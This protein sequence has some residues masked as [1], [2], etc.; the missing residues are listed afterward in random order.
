MQFARW[1]ASAVQLGTGQI[2]LIGGRDDNPDLTHYSAYAEVYTPGYGFHTLTGAYIDAFNASSAL[3]PRTWLTSS[4][5]VW[6]SD[7]ANI[8]SINPTGVGSVQ[9]IGQAPTQILWNIPAIMFAPDKVLLIGSDDSAWIMDMSGPTPVFQRTD[10]VTGGRIWSN[11]V[12]LPDGRVMISGGSAVDNQ[13]TGVDNTAAIWDPATGHWTIEANAAIPRLYHSDTILLADGSV[14]SLG[15][16][17]PGPLTNLNGEEY[18]PGYLFDVTGAPAVRPVIEDAPAQVQP[19]TEFTMHVDNPASIT[20]LALMPFGAVTHSFDMSARRLE[21]PFTVQADGSLK[22]DLPANSNLLT[23]GYWMLFAI[24]NND[25]PSIA[26]TVQVKTDPM[27]YDLPAQRPL[28]LLDSNMALQ[29][30]GDAAYDA[31]NDRYVLTPDA[32]TKHGSFIS[33]KR[34]D[35]STA[36]DISFQINLGGK[37]AGGDGVGFVLENDPAGIN[38]IGAAGGGQGL[39]GIQY[40]LGITFATNAATDQ[41]GFVKTADGSAQSVAVGLGNIEDGRWHQVYVVSNGQTISYTFDG[42]QMGAISLAAANALLNGSNLAYFGFTGDTS[43]ATEQ[44]QIQLLKLDATAEGGQQIHLDRANLPPGPLGPNKDPIAVN[45]AYTINKN[46]VLTV[47]AAAGVLANDYDPDGDP[48]RICPESRIVG[49]ALLL[50]PTNGAVTMNADGSFTYTPNT[51]FAG[52]DS[53]Y[54]CAEDG[55]ACAQGRV[56]ITV[57]G[58]GTPIN[59]ILGTPGNDVLVGTAGN[60][61]MSGGAGNDI[62]TGGRGNDTFVFGPG[63]GNDT[64]TDWSRARGNRDIIDL[65][66]FNFASFTDV[67]NRLVVNGADT[68]FNFGNGDTLTLQNTAAG[69]VTNLLVDDFKLSSASPV[70]TSPSTWTANQPV[71]IFNDASGNFTITDNVE[72]EVVGASTVNVSFASG[73]T[74]EL[75]LDASSQF[76]GQVTGFTDK[77]LLDLADIAL[78]SNTTLG[79]VANSNNTGGTLKV[80]DGTNTANIALL[81]QYTAASFVMATDG[82]GGTLIHDPPATLAQTLAQPQQA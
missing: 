74:G 34:V 9:I 71:V 36:F 65:S 59:T 42:V 37:D 58:T 16:G 79:Y 12:V 5:T 41:T 33:P 72:L 61:W 23:P 47:S 69:N 46:G 32:P 31:Y 81:G 20:T 17:A 51:G 44:E 39:T 62:L 1:Y 52:V 18:K 4:G 48:L 28:D 66:A 15:G 6:T 43:A 78:G 64:I 35:L 24:N 67:L 50:A 53:F 68:V 29:R 75:K 3:Y 13:L 14:L 55:P 57:T 7:G 2:L 45:D 10:D 80:S 76:T 82:S 73:S 19:G 30:N 56:D 21:L 26:S 63:F 25:V 22:V 38:A 77:N 54:Y 60:D 27:L 11:L 40:G 8:Y 70:S 49:H